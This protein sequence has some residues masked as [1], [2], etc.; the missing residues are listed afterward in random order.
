MANRVSYIFTATDKFSRISD[1]IGRKTDKIR[2]KFSRL[3]TTVKKSS[4]AMDKSSRVITSGFKRMAAAAAA[5]FGVRGLVSRGTEFQDA[6]ADL[7]AITGLA[8]DD[9]TKLSDDMFTLGAESATAAAKV[10]EGFKLV[11][12]AKPELLENIPALK[13]VTREVLLLK[14]AAGIDLVDAA[15]IA[16]QSLNIFGAEADQANRFVNVL[17]AGAKL[18]SSEITDTGE[19]TL[20]AGPAARAAGLSFEQLTAAIQTT[21]RGG[22]KGA[23]AGTA[24]NSILGRL[25]RAGIDFQKLGLQG[26]FEL[27]KAKMDSLTSSTARAQFAATLF[28]EEHQKVGF[29]I[30]AN[31]E[32]LGLY[33]RILTGTNVAQDQADKR[34]ATLSAKARVLGVVFNKHVIKAFL[35]LEPLLSSLTIKMTEFFASIDPR[36][37]K[38]LSFVIGSLLKIVAIQGKVLSFLIPVFKFV[39]AIVKGWVTTFT[40]LVTA[41]STFSFSKF[42]PLMEAFS[43]GGK[44]LGLFGGDELKMGGVDV[45]QSSR[46]D[47]NVNLNAPKGAVDSVQKRTTGR[48]GGM[49]V[50]VNMATQ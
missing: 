50:G 41:I 37:I 17:A 22:I 11:A 16:A 33:E 27:I 23:R 47:V 13:A 24:L 26:S 44:F 40:G 28:G 46:T 15:N 39:A 42:T 3:T 19:A 12:S 38:D 29:A 2:K 20:L 10:A 25:Q 48:I 4:V 1:K 9:L 21:A 49:N 18:G 14:N 43:L 30:L 32:F 8:G 36:T 34:L 31:V 5:F 35:E 6:L 7:S 45:T